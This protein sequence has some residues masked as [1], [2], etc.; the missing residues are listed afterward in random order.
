[1][2]KDYWEKKMPLI[3]TKY[4]KT[5]QCDTPVFHHP[6][7]VEELFSVKRIDE[8]GIFAL[9]M[10]KYSKTYVLSDINFAGVTDS[11]QKTIIINFSKVLNSM[12]CRFSYCV[13]NEHVDAEELEKKILY[14][15]CGD[16]LDEVREAFNEV[17]RTKVTDAKQGLYQTIYLTLTVEADSMPE[18]KSMFSGMEAA[19]GKALIQ[20]GV[21]GMAGASMEALDINRRMQAWVNFTHSGLYSNFRFNFDEAYEQ[22]HDWIDIV[23]P[24]C[25]EIYNDFFIMNGNRYG[26]VM[27]IAKHPQSMES[28]IISE[29]SK[30]NATTY[31]T[32]NSEILELSGFKEEINRKFASVGMKIESQKQRNRNNNDFLSDASDKLLAEKESL[33]TLSRNVE[34]GDDH[35]FN[36]TVLIMFLSN[37]FEEMEE[38]TKKIESLGGI[39]SFEAKPCFNKQREGINSAFMFG[40]QEFKRCV[41]LSAPC[42]AMYMPF[43]TQ[44][45]NDENG[46]FYGINRLSQNPIL[47]DRKNLQSYHGVVLGSTRSG[48]SAFAKLE[49][50]SNR[51][52][53]PEDQM[54]IID[55]QNEYKKIASVKGVNGIVISFDTQKEVF[56]NPMDVN[57]DGVDY[58]ELQEIIAEK[59]DFIITL[60]SNCMKREMNAAE[61]GILDKVISAVYSE[62]YALRKK[63]NGENDTISEFSV[64]AYMQ[65]NE[66][67]LPMKAA[68]SS[69]EQE[70][71]YS[72]TLQDVYQKLMDMNSDP[73]AQNLAGSMQVFVN[74]SLNLFNHKTNVDLNNK[75]LVFDLSGIKENLRITSMLV[76]LEITRNKIK[77]NFARGNWTNIYIDEFHELLRIPSVAD[78]V[79]RLWKEVGK[80]HGAMTGITQ[81]MTDLLNNS[82]DSARLAAILSNTEYFAMLNQS[83][84]DRRML[85]DFLPSIS[86][87]MFNFVEGATAGTGLL[88]MGPV[89]VPFDVHME[90]SCRL[91]E[92]VNTDGNDGV[93]EM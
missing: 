60:L 41:N 80:L 35:Y 33:V 21:N 44:E 36:T 85:A 89:T 51:C 1:M 12:G 78:Y 91:Y 45:L 55:P 92:M 11:E 48:K 20:I 58:S 79:I 64:P 24:E 43:K 53:H 73:I 32:V 90:K 42:E 59:S 62:N 52:R 34:S 19:L 88:K 31:I 40:I 67:V 74:G 38:I 2:R 4:G 66:T 37:S 30:I 25:M 18:A 63:I 82:P 3:I 39:K 17:I 77:W 28:D 93:G 72:P 57:F 83:T 84:I 10:K 68:F 61:Q 71:V 76:M 7:S 86:P 26:R 75:F 29:L 13:A 5:K 27:Y 65:S 54:L 16:D 50:L 87:A 47:S 69:E 70:R 22:N 46:S 49:I 56:V 15:K 8:S 14:K 9:N 23:S 81:N 6:R